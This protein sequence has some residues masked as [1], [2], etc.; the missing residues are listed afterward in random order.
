M[1]K[2]SETSEKSNDCSATFKFSKNE[3]ETSTKAAKFNSNTVCP[4][5]SKQKYSDF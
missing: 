1:N 4:K 2:T 3:I 5:V